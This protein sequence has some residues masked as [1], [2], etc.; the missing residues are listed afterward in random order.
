MIRPRY[1]GR[2][3]EIPIRL[4]RY[5]RVEVEVP[6]RA[7]AKDRLLRNFWALMIGLI[8]YT[9]M[10]FIDTSGS[11]TVNQITGDIARGTVRAIYTCSDTSEVPFNAYSCSLVENLGT[12][13]SWS[14][15]ISGNSSI[16]EVMD[17]ATK[18]ANSSLLVFG[19]NEAV[20]SPTGK[21]I[22]VSHVL[23]PISPSAVVVHRIVATTPLLF[24]LVAVLRAIYHDTNAQ[25]VKDINGTD[26]YL[27][28]AS[29]I[30]AGAAG[31]YL[32]TGT[33]PVSPT[34]Y[35]LTNPTLLPT[36]IYYTLTDTF[37]RIDIYGS[38]YPNVDTTFTE[39]G[40]ALRLYDTGGQA[41][42]ILVLRYLLPQP[43]TA[44]AGKVYT[45]RLSLYGS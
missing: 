14:L 27:R 15:Y 21:T 23:Q 36:V 42:D 26:I 37:A 18:Y 7:P 10:T 38:I 28:G 2:L 24:N 13:A 19:L 43:L 29:T 32:G 45:I 20:V 11:S 12:E 9:N 3:I 30:L 35:T 40:L 22:A 4:D 39:V 41:R 5:L 16:F 8:Y 17:T 34:D 33:R 25:S 31:L 1:R 44:K 6:G